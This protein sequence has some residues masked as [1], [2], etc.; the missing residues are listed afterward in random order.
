MMKR[1][2]LILATLLGSGVLAVCGAT[3][4]RTLQTQAPENNSLATFAP[5]GA[6]LAIESPDFHALL[7]SWSNSEEEKR[8][9]KSDNYAGFSR[10]RLFSRLGEA[11]GQFAATAG[12]SPDTAFL[13]QVAGDQ[14]LFA[15]YDIG[16]LEFLYVTH[17]PGGAAA[18]TPLLELRDK[19]EE[20]RVGDTTFYVRT[21]G[22]PARTVAFAVRGDYLLL[23]TREDLIANALQL[24]QH[25]V[26]ATLVHEHWYAEAASATDQKPGDLRMTLNLTKIVP[27]PYFRSYWIQQNITEMKQ[28]STALSDLYRAPDNFREERVLIAAKPS[29]ETASTDLAPV[30][31]Y[32]PEHSGVYRAQAQPAVSAILD[33]FEDKLLSR[34]ISDYRDPHV[35]PVA[36]LSTPDAGDTSNLDERIDETS[37]PVQ[38]RSAS[39]SQL[40]DLL[41]SAHPE[42]MLIYSAT[43]SQIRENVFAPI[44]TA[45]VLASSAGWSQAVWQESLSAALAPRITV[46]KTGLTWQERHRDN[47]NWV[48]LSGMHGV[49]V[50]VQG[51]ICVVASDE[52][53][54]LRLLEAAQH[55][56]K[57]PKMATT[58]AGFD[59]HSEREGF[60]RL[61]GLLDGAG[62]STQ[63]SS[64]ATPAFFSKNLGSL[65]NTFQDLD[66]ET[67]TQSAAANG[68]THQT[69]V[70]QW[71]R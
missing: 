11:Q 1:S 28:Y 8:W 41:V 6:L 42:A 47:L 9:L 66:A 16:N 71:H 63:Q 30:L 56:T 40:H 15:W 59:H 27:S 31:G 45:V 70:Y 52:T 21:Q 20:R 54:L 51:N 18:K 67:F 48:T 19:F 10:S 39:L 68:A 36:D 25:P 26:D 29:Q 50:A 38:P 4:Y 14:S 3:V 60:T 34:T 46:G 49:A 2:H 23:A 55:A 44:H 24:M 62:G 61:T 69:I 37:V 53:T 58:I 43:D 5:Q 7:K 64:D 33:Q 22:D 32:L 65:S 35:A 17:M 13:Q 12:L 57:E